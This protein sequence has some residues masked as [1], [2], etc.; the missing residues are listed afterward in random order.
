MKDFT[1]R[2]PDTTIR[3]TREFNRDELIMALQAYLSL[4]G[5]T[6]PKGEV[7]IWGLEYPGSAAEETLTLVIDS[8]ASD[9][10]EEPK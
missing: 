3:Y 4:G 10:R 9:Y 5:I 2:V 6:V 7:Q 8:K 1:A